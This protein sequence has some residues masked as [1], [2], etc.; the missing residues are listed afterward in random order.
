MQLH[1]KATVVL[2]PS[3][4]SKNL[5]IVCSSLDRSLRLGEVGQHNTLSPSFPTKA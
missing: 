1:A 3:A 2:A 5:V 4:N